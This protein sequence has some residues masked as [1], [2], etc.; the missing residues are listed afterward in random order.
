MRTAGSTGPAFDVVGCAAGLSVSGEMLIVAP[1]GIG[2]ST[3]M[4]QLADAILGAGERAAALVRLGEWSIRAESIF[5][6][7]S[8]RG[9]FLGVSEHD[10]VLLANDGMLTVLLDGW[11]ELDSVSRLSAILEV[12]R[13]KREFPLLELAISTR[14][15]S[16]DLPISGPTVEIL[17]LAQDQQLEIALA[18]AG[19]EGEALLDRAWRTPGLRE[20]VS[21]PLYLNGLM[22]RVPG[23]MMPQS[24]EAMLRLLVAEHE[25]SPDTLEILHTRLHDLHRDVLIALAV[26]ATKA[27]TTAI[28]GSRARSVVSETFNQLRLR[29][30][31]SDPPQP[32]E[33][34]D[35]LAGRH[36]LLWS[37]S[38]GGLLFHHEQIQEWFASFEVERLMSSTALGDAGAS[39]ELRVI[40]DSPR[41]EEPILF[42]CER[43]SRS[44]S[45]GEEAVAAAVIE[46]LSI[47]PMLAADMIYRSSPSVWQRNKD[48]VIPLIV[49]WHIDGNVDRAARFMVTTG[50]EEFAPQIWPLIANPDAQVHLEALRVAAQFR[51]G[52]LGTAAR[53]RLLELPDSVRANVLSEI[54]S[55]GGMDEMDLAAEVAK[56]DPSSQVQAEVIEALQ[57]RRSD[58]LAIKVLETAPPE[59][60]SL[61][62]RRGFASRI[63][64]AGA[65]ARLRTLETSVIQNDPD[66]L[67]RLRLLCARGEDAANAEAIEAL[68][69]SPDFPVKEREHVWAIFEASRR[70]GSAV[71]QGLLRRLSNGMAI[72]PGSEEL[73]ASAPSVDSGPIAM[74]VT[75]LDTPSDVAGSAVSVIGPKSVGA[76][77]DQLNTLIEG[78]RASGDSWSGSDRDKHSRLLDLII[79]TRPG[80]FF[81][82]WLER[83][84]TENPYAIARLSDLVVRHG[85]GGASSGELPIRTELRSSVVAALRWQAETLLRSPE[86]TRHH[87][88]ELARAMRRVPSPEYF[89]VLRRF[90]AE[91]LT[92]WRRARDE[93]FKH[94]GGGMS[95]DASMCYTREYA[96]ALAAI[97]DGNTIEFL[98]SYLRDPLF[99]NDAAMA[100]RE[101]WT[102]RHSGQF[103]RRPVVGQGFSDVMRQRDERSTGEVEPSELG[104]AIFT[105]V[106]ELLKPGR[107]ET[108]C[109]HALRL[110]IVAFQ[111]P[112]CDKEAL[113]ASLFSLGLPAAAKR[114]L[115]TVLTLAGETV[116]ADF[117]MGGIREFLN[118]IKGNPWR[119]H[120]DNWEL[121]GWLKVLPF[122]NR[123]ASV[124]EV[125]KLLSENPLNPWEL[126]G[127]LSSLGR[128]PEAEALRVLKDM[129]ILDPRLIAENEWIEAALGRKNESSCL[130][131]LDL[132]CDPKTA[133]GRGGIHGWVFSRKVAEVV[134]RIPSFRALLIRRYADPRSSACDSLIEGI[135]A[136]V[137]DENVILAMVQRYAE[138]GRTFDGHLR[139]A[140]VAAVVARRPVPDWP[141][142]YSSF[143]VPAPILRKKL[144]ALTGSGGA[145]SHLAAACLTAIDEARDEYGRPNAEPRHPDVKAGRPW[146]LVVLVERVGLP[147]FGSVGSG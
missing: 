71:A 28:E 70:R 115:V 129:A 4:V 34:L 95:A 26:D 140:V 117:V 52:V 124:L 106:E 82:A 25:S 30:Q 109:L 39:T 68:L 33:V 57:F 17:P 93:H 85:H 146:P 60:W 36:T 46:A 78:V 108:E 104:E 147:G 86:A 91:D 55:N 43:L 6:S 100:L 69:G 97:G 41:W 113:I 76:L 107:S 101:I 7:L 131:V 13:L 48:R 112:Y 127:V 94:P 3:T 67:L 119:I 144:F 42:S 27:G 77:I 5:E 10:F 96:E 31:V 72:P 45:G 132:L 135:L 58:R 84:K 11:N 54:V 9:A 16:G 110:A 22:G 92:R 142:A 111:M 125:L 51:R 102:L 136:A 83:A 14:P 23:K 99:G 80:P 75:N 105:V 59:V 133:V 89:D 50:K 122:T 121:L 53:D 61:L 81:E 1:P 56:L 123:P 74:A 103:D 66:Q 21:I 32:S 12:G 88:V 49:A 19:T 8:H 40:L 24:K 73:L 126:R 29:G 47:D 65:L 139:S 90:V 18:S 141:G 63:L 20:L 114:D 64:D 87:Y 130:M 116:D 79:R 137:P 128:A 145:Q 44:G 138:A 2:K 37:G 35:I 98:E 62:A 118:S 134:E 15:Q 38:S 120:Q 143:S